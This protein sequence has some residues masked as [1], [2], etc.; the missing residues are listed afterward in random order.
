VV[1]IT[2]PCALVERS[3][4]VM[5][6]I[7]RLV[8]VALVV[9]AFP[10]MTRLPFTVDDAAMRPFENVRTEVVALL[11]N[12]SWSVV[13]VASVPQERTPA[14]D[15]LTSQD[16][17]FK[18]ET[19]RPVVEARPETERLVVVAFVVVVLVKMLPA[20]QVFAAYSFGIVVEASM[21]YVALVV[22]QERPADA[23]YVE[24]VVLKKLFTF[25]QASVEVVENERPTDVKYA[26]ELVEKKLLAALYASA[27]VVAHERPTD[28]KYVALEVL[29]K[30]AVFF[31]ASALVVEKKKPLLIP[32]K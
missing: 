21:K 16:A 20:V 17:L 5:L 4:F 30:L 19:M 7:A 2:L 29:K 26:A 28:E 25:F 6:E 27:E 31:Q 1:A 18:L 3:A 14:G 32:L 8:V 11:G 9:V 23:K 15:A 24:E 13:P 12:G 10:V 22:D